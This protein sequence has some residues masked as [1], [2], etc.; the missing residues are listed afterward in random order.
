MVGDAE[1]IPEYQSGVPPASVSLSPPSVVFWDLGNVS[2]G[3]LPSCLL[4]HSKDG[5]H[6]ARVSL[7]RVRGP[8]L[9]CQVV[10]GLVAFSIK[11]KGFS[12]LQ[13]QLNKA[14]SRLRNL[15]LPL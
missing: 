12:I 15:A 1:S 11:G 14:L 8:L 2:M 5:R 3:P 4:V 13:P 9:P 10:G 6:C 7:R